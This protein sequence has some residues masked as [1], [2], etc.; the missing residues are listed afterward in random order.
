MFEKMILDDNGIKGIRLRFLKGLR[1]SVLKLNQDK[2]YIITLIFGVL[3]IDL[4]F[5]CVY[6]DKIIR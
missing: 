3:W 5:S 2:D 6:S 1:F 4:Q